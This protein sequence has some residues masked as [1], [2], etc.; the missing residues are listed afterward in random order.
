MLSERST[1]APR[2]GAQI[3]ER[4][5]GCQVC[6]IDQDQFPV[7]DHNILGMKIAVHHGVTF[8]DRVHFRIRHRNSQTL[9]PGAVQFPGAE[10]STGRSMGFMQLLHYLRIVL[11]NDLEL[12]RMIVPASSL[13]KFNEQKDAAEG[14]RKS[15]DSNCYPRSFAFVL[16]IS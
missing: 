4:V 2:H 1:R 5:S 14:Y 6:H 10:Q 12:I 13:F 8:G 11:R 3:V 16:F 7:P 15:V 9:D